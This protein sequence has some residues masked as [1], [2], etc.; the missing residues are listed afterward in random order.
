MNASPQSTLLRVMHEESVE[1]GEALVGVLSSGVGCGIRTACCVRHL[2]CM[3][4]II[5][6]LRMLNT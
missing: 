1:W 6:V 5:A 2:C 4:A 3:M